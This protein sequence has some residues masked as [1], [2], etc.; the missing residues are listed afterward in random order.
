MLT[1]MPSLTVCAW[2]HQAVAWA[3][4]LSAPGERI[5][6]LLFNSWSPATALGL[7]YNKCHLNILE[8]CLGGPQKWYN[9]KSEPYVFIKCLIQVPI[10]H[11]DF[12]LNPW[13]SN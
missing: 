12:F 4:R 3:T 10:I 8:E 1:T 2:C 9:S 11:E 6:R 7:A 13:D 5:L